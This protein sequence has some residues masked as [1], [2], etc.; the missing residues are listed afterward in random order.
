MEEFDEYVHKITPAEADADNTRT[1]AVHSP[2]RWGVSNVIVSTPRGG[3]AAPWATAEPRRP[4]SPSLARQVGRA[5]SWVRGY[6]H[7]SRESLPLATGPAEAESI[8]ED[9]LPVFPPIVIE[10]LLDVAGLSVASYSFEAIQLKRQLTLERISKLRAEDKSPKAQQRLTVALVDEYSKIA[11]ADLANLGNSSP[12]KLGIEFPVFSHQKE[13]A[14][15]AYQYIFRALTG[16]SY[17]YHDLRQ[18][19]IRTVSVPSADR[20]VILPDYYLVIRRDF[21]QGPYVDQYVAGSLED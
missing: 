18:D 15:L 8:N 21:A 2:V 13:E 1:V 6:R 16:K 17:N 14:R 5:V 4:R 3:E 19:S 12:H 7:T 10:K 20:G 11:M 9:F